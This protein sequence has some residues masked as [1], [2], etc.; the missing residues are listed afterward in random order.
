MQNMPQLLARAV[1]L[2]FLS[3]LFCSQCALA[4]M[5]AIKAGRLLDVDAANVLKDQIILVEDGKVKA[6]GSDLA[7]PKTS[8]IIDLSKQTVLP[9]LID[10]HTHLVGSADPDPIIE[11]QKTAAQRAFESIPNA[12]KTLEA[13]FTT[14][15]DV[16]A[17]RAL[18]DVALRDAINR[19]DLIGPRMFVAGAYITISGGG[20]ALTGMA[21]DIILPQD[22]RF[23]EANDP[24]T[25]RKRVRELA[26]R[27]VDHIKIIATGAV[28]THGSNPSSEEF[29]PEEMQ[30]AVEEAHKFGLKVAAHAHSAQGIKDAT[31]AGAASI[32]HGTYLDEEGIALMKAHG[33]YLV[34]DI[35]DD[36]YIMGEGKEKGVPKDF[37][38]HEANLGAIQR[39]NFRKAVAAGVKVAFGTDAGVFPHGLN[40][41]QFAYM[42]KYGLSPMQAI[43]SATIWAADLIGKSAVIGSIKPGKFADIVAVDGDPLADIRTLENVKFVMKDGKIFKP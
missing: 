33:T 35:Y 24:W 21:P 37:Q 40:G 18:T 6:V 28:L 13:G 7:I 25:V 32:E 26:N 16:G 2:L 22:L 29:T 4:D 10:C 42:V 9:G 36:D 11:L 15:R 14:V 34:A 1:A 12:R 23:G 30:A 3:L 19:G 27:G 17:Y 39:E 43:Q 31:R 5:L 41:R 8:K 38:E 20:G